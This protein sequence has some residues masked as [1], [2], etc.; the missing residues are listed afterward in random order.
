MKQKIGILPQ[1][2]ATNG[3]SRILPARPPKPALEGDRKADWV[4]V[5]A[6]WAGLA[7]ARR[8]AENCPDQEISLIEAHEVGE[9]ASGRNSG[10][11]IDLPHNVGSSLEELDSSRAYMRLARA[12]ISALKEAVTTYG[13]ACDW[14]RRGKY[15]TAVSARGRREILEP[16]AAELDAL[17]EPYAWIEGPA[18]ADR[19]GTG[20]YHSSV[21]T[22]GCVLMNPAAL[23]RGLA[24]NLPE[25]VTLYE[26]SPVTALERQNGVSLTLPGGTLRAPKMILA[27]NGFAPQFGFYRNRTFTLAA[28]AS[29]TRPLDKEERAA[30]GGEEDWGLTPANAFAG[31]TMRFTKDWRILIRQNIHF[32][33]DFR[34]PPTRLA[35]IREE[36]QR[37][38]LGRFPMLPKV[39]MEHS[40]TG[41]LCLSQN[42]APG[43]GMIAPGIYTAVCQNAVGVTK[44]TIGGILAA[45]SAS[46]R[47]NPLI[48]DM[49]SLGQPNRL[50]PRPFL[51]VGLRSRFAWELWRARHEA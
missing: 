8:L 31:I 24:D 43:F 23:S 35:E 19:I 50:P 27:V 25:N 36:H 49:E 18:L 13:I 9:N 46:G 37:L 34:I 41:F 33:P 4:V 26:H 15:H 51:D 11:A 28:H 2:D 3:W 47:D 42:H 10:F 39:T 32:Q 6:G 45:D 5:G 20:Y 38:F 22:P 40:W 44:G 12:A 21:Y 30:L 16:F 48:A 1:N 7:A 14:S 29:L 17:E